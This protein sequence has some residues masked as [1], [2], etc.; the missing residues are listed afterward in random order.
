[1]LEYLIPGGLI[2]GAIY[3]FTKSDAPSQPSNPSGKPAYK[4]GAGN[5]FIVSSVKNLPP[6]LK[7]ML[8][9]ADPTAYTRAVKVGDVIAYALGDGARAK[10]G[11][12]V[13][14][15]NSDHLLDV[16]AKLI[17]RDASM[18]ST[19]RGEA[20]KASITYAKLD[21]GESSSMPTQLPQPGVE[22]TL[23]RNEFV[24]AV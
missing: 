14:V 15:V 24:P 2:L 21:A 20:W 5:W 8:D 18:D 17:S 13:T 1:M 9:A 12:V 6:E 11:E 7:A 23:F 19:E 4:P 10:K 3:F 16:Q 22:V